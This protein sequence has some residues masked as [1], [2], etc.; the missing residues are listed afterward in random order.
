MK[1]RVCIIAEAGVNHNGDID[2]ALKLCDAA[3]KAGADI[4][5]FQTFCTELNV[6]PDCEMA[7]YQRS[8][9]GPRQSQWEM[10]KALEL[11][12]D[13]FRRIKEYCDEINIEFLST[14]SEEKSLDFILSLGTDK[15]KISSGEI[16]NVPFLRRIGALKKKVILSTGMA[17]LKEVENAIQLLVKSGTPKN[18]ITVLQCNTEYPTP[19]EDVNLLAMFTIK[20]TFNV[21]VGYSDHTLGIEIPVAA[22]A[23]GAT[24]IEKHFTLKRDMEGPDHKAS[25][26]PAELEAMVRAIRN[27]E[28]ALGNGIKKPTPSELKN[29]KIARKTIVAARDIKK[30]EIFTEK[31]IRVKRP[32]RGLSAIKWDKVIGKKA[33]KDF[34]I[35]EPVKI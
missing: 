27:V 30:G 4:I 29:R 10:L 16:T 31:N 3:K 19:V 17:D 25:L 7:A 22:A 26:E 15:L 1:N 21:K 12:Y 34:S 32:E 35:D 2:L 11:S 24:I 28:L 8:N 23:L 18:D 9:L 5:K 14:P 20:K 6:I 33:K 13:E